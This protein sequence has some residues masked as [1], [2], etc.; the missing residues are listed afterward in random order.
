MIKL[1][2]LSEDRQ[3]FICDFLQ[4]NIKTALDNRSGL[5]KKYEKWTNQFEAKPDKEVKNFP[6][7]KASN[8]VVPMQSI[9]VNALVAR[10]IQSINASRPF[11]TVTPLSSKWT[12][13][14]MPNQRLMD[15]AQ[16]FEMKMIANLVP[17]LYDQGNLGTAFAK[18]AW[19]RE[20][21]QNKTYNDDG[22]I[23]LYEQE[24]SDGPRFI[25]IHPSDFIMPT[26][27]IQSLQDCPWVAHRFR[28]NWWT[29]LRRSKGIDPAY[30]N[31]EKIKSWFKQEADEKT[32]K[33]EQREHLF[34]SE[35]VREYE[36]FEVWAEF[37]YDDDGIYEQC[38]FTYSLDAN[39]LV[40]PTLNPFIH[41]W[42]P[43]VSNQCFPRPHRV[44][45]I[46]YGQKLERLQEG[47]STAANQAID[48]ASLANARC[49]KAK[50]NSGIKPGV[51]I[52][53]GKVFT[54]ADMGDLETFQLG[55]IYPSSAMIINFLRDFSERDTGVSDY[56]LGKESQV[57]GSAATATSTLALIQEGSKMF[58]FLL[59]NLRQTLNEVA[60]QVYSL[61]AQ[62]KP[63]GLVF[64]LEGDDAKLVE[65]T[66]KAPEGDVR[67][68][69]QFDL[70]ASSAY[71]NAALERESWVQLFSLLQGYYSKIF[72]ATQVIFEPQAP[73]QLKVLAGKMAA[74]G[75]L[76]M[77]RILE[78]WNILDSDRLL[79]PTEDLISIMGSQ[80]IPQM[81]PNMT[82]EMMGQFARGKEPGA[83]PPLRQGRGNVR[84]LGG[85]Q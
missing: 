85:R 20:T 13:Y 21:Y 32:D 45:G 1:L 4:E 67:K 50:R 63:S 53:P 52:Y 31:T 65:E 39:T 24:R 68:G 82:P 75:Q 79:I 64:S 56:S 10:H 78:K 7:E 23:I 72:E 33:D 26:T 42:R 62:F 9:T 84:Q 76:V 61:Y 16:R 47:I 12:D 29:I 59:T 18:V 57:V 11:W 74:S 55:D 41:G 48:N 17:F 27:S 6:F 35:N 44:L 25:P 73:P 70:T 81:P 37:D 8:L 54:L 40:R 51:K 77:Q 60:Y 69:L 30:I 83:P 3:K 58:D 22:E 5:E 38:V 71:V 43:F 2:K 28:L 14:A 80:N 15:Y 66:W 46:G 49:L 36:L 34:R 19:I